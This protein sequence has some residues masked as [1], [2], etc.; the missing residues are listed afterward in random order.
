MGPIMCG[1]LYFIICCSHKS[2]HVYSWLKHLLG[3]KLLHYKVNVEKHSANQMKQNHWDSQ[4][5]LQRVLRSKLHLASSYISMI[6]VTILDHAEM[7]V[8]GAALPTRYFD[9]LYQHSN[10]LLCP[11]L[12]FMD[13]RDKK[14]GQNTA[15]WSWESWGKDLG[16]K[17][18]IFLIEYLVSLNFAPLLCLA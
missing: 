1:F 6:E 18:A 3:I 10:L 12:S 13:S 16:K 17:F 7:Y 14:Q 5:V 8:C 11:A 4:P 15:I 9:G 2:R